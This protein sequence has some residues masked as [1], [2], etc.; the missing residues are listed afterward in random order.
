MLGAFQE[1]S[2]VVGHVHFAQ[3]L[4]RLLGVV[5]SVEAHEEGGE[6]VREVGDLGHVQL[7]A[8]GLV[9]AAANVHGGQVGAH[10]GLV[11][12]DLAASAG[13]A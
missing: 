9:H 8:N 13:P 11:V 6:R 2:L 12:V 1:P 7:E 3:Q 4:E 10:N 5:L